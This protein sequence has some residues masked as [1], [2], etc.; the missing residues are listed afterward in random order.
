MKKGP[1]DGTGNA[2]PFPNPKI[3]PFFMHFPGYLIS[4]RT[5]SNLHTI[6]HHSCVRSARVGGLS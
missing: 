2:S 6:A 1:I 3:G 5:Q 4:G